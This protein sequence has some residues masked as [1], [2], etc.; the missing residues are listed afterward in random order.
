MSHI[1]VLST[2]C[3]KSGRNQTHH[4]SHTI[5]AFQFTEGRLDNWEDYCPL[6]Y[7]CQIPTDQ[8]EYKE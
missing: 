8:V 4:I 6:F 3:H 7:A 5:S 1:V 2:P